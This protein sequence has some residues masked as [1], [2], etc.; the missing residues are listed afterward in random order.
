MMG[1]QELYTSSLILQQFENITLALAHT[2][3]RKPQIV[4]FLSMLNH[5]LGPSF[6]IVAFVSIFKS[7][8]KVIIN[9]WNAHYCFLTA[10]HAVT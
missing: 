4:W 6:I 1:A 5:L 9:N 10:E 8:A 3:S 7:D 2:F